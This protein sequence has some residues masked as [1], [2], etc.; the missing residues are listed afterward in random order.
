[1]GESVF[2]SKLIFKGYTL[3]WTG[4]ILKFF[5]QLDFSAPSPP[6]CPQSK[7]HLGLGDANLREFTL[8]LERIKP[9]S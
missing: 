5:G 9:L 2:R 3:K 1:M 7:E 8:S 6:P 4:L